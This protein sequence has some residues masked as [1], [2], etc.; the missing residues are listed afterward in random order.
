MAEHTAYDLCDDEV[1]EGD[2]VEIEGDMDKKISAIVGYGK[3][4][5]LR[6]TG[7]KY[8]NAHDA[9]EY[10]AVQ[11]V[12]EMEK[13]SLYACPRIWKVDSYLC[14][15]VDAADILEEEEEEECIEDLPNKVSSQSIV[16]YEV[17]D[18]ID[19]GDDFD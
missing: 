16:D 9:Q 19:L 14:T 11:L 2:W 15:L 10:P 1:E 5:E 17:V 13:S 6:D 12:V 18:L 7:R 4:V 8:V 3:V